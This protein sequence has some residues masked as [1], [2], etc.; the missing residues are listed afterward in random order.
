MYLLDPRLGLDLAPNLDIRSELKLASHSE[1]DL[2]PM[3]VLQM[4]SLLEGLLEHWMVL[5][6]EES[7]V[8]NLVLRKV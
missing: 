1:P 5:N 7:K 2:E 4:A 6:W 3:K 8:E